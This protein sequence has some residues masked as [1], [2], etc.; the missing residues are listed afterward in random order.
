M[1]AMT[2][3]FPT[4]IS[5]QINKIVFYSG[6]PSDTKRQRIAKHA[7]AAPVLDKTRSQARRDAAADLQES[8]NSFGKIMI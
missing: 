7:G 5:G 8:R 6:P 3:S 2:T 1:E 4:A